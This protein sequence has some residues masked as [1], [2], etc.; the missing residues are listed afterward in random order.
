MVRHKRTGSTALVRL[1]EAARVN[2]SSSLPSSSLVV[3]LIFVVVMIVGVDGAQEMR[4][5]PLGHVAA[6]PSSLQVRKAK[7]DT[8]VDAG[9]DY[10][11]GCI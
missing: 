7:V 8:S 3:S 6:L 11:R 5:D 10:V 9:V 4:E 1:R 2:H